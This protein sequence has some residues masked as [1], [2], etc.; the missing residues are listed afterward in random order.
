ML[1]VTTEHAVRALVELARSPA[2]AI[3]GHEL[4]DRARIPSQYQAK[5]LG[6]LIGAGVVSAVRGTGG[7][8]RLA[9]PADGIRL[10][11]VVALFDPAQVQ[12]RCLLH[13][14][15]PC[16]D[17]AP[18]AAHAEWSAVRTRIIAFLES[19]T[20]ATVARVTAADNNRGP[21]FPTNLPKTRATRGRMPR[22][23][24]AR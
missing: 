20:I 10:A 3:V 21:A 19:T 14:E 6:V 17:D 15:R 7:G 2:Q 22:S 16:R 11:D 1:S 5:I 24:R 23:R 12:G 4:A 13:C 8:Y 18:C 9:Q